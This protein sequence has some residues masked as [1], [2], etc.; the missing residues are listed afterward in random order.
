ME[1]ELK[2]VEGNSYDVQDKLLFLALINGPILFGMA[3]TYSKLWVNH[4]GSKPTPSLRGAGYYDIE[5]KRIQFVEAAFGR[6]IYEEHQNIGASQAS[7][8]EQIAGQALLLATEV[9]GLRRRVHS[10]PEIR[11]RRL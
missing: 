3:L 5:K 11:I 9:A 10:R 8:A 4:A 2:L 7:L 6:E 1:P